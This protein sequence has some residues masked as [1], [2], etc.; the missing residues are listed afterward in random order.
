[1][2]IE[3][4]VENG[5]RYTQFT[6]ATV[7]LRLDQLSST[8]SFGVTSTE[9]KP[10]PFKGGEACRVLVAGQ[11]VLTGFIEVVSINYD[12]TSHSISIAGRDKTGDLIDS[13]IDTLSDIKPPLTL[14]QIIEKIIANVGSRV[15]VID[16]ISPEP[17]NKAEDLISPEPGQIAFELM[18]KYAR[19]RQVLLSSNA[20]GDIV[21]ARAE[22]TVL[23]CRLN[24]IINGGKRNNILRCAASYDT[25]GRFNVYKFVSSLNP[26][27][28]N[29][30]G[31]I[32][33]D[34]VVDQ[35]GSAQ[36]SAIRVGRQRILVAE[37]PFSNNENKSRAEWEANIR[38]AR[39][40]VYSAEVL[41]FTYDG[42]NLWRLNA[43][44]PIYD[45]FA[46][47]DALMLINSITFSFDLSGGSVTT[48]GCIERNAYSLTLAEPK[49]EKIADGFF[50]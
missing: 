18:E 11:V 25:T 34:S 23:P 27:A 7:E 32:G 42:T 15:G 13:N 1:M 29:A 45:E 8:F 50:I 2:I 22:A 21:I 33:L 38:K 19:K 4:E 39:G 48:L 16:S 40:R 20:D 10:L 49:T 44:V 28:L 24:N 12:A 31:T 35:K 6:E 30:A 47:I 17:F 37:T 46:G 9:A 5:K 14:K 26:I 36:D 41:G 43:L 3:L